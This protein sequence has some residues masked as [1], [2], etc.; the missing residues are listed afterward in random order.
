MNN[1]KNIATIGIVGATLLGL[2]G[3]AISITPAVA[4]FTEPKTQTLSFQ[5]PMNIIESMEVSLTFQRVEAEVITTQP[6]LKPEIANQQLN[7]SELI[8]VLRSVGFQGSSLKMAWAI[9]M[10]ESTR[11]P[12]AHND[13]PSTGDNSY[14]LFQIN[15]RGAMGPERLNKYGLETNEDLF[16][17]ITNASIAYKMSD[18]GKNWSAWTTYEKAKGIVNQFPN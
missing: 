5:K 8:S 17:P 6:W 12:F 14:G 4:D 3:T 16:E 1:K 11:R 18:G 10:K 2:T 15:M 9:V 7:N 13:N